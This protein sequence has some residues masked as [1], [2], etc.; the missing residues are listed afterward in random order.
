MQQTGNDGER[1]NKGK[2]LFAFIDKV[3]DQNQSF[4]NALEL[5]SKIGA[6]DEALTRFFFLFALS[7]VVRSFVLTQN[8][9][10]KSCLCSFEPERRVLGSQIERSGSR[11]PPF[12]VFRVFCDCLFV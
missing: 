4:D 3:L 9:L 12:G 10:G 5:S 2:Q 7:L 1:E 11:F 6:G 8:K